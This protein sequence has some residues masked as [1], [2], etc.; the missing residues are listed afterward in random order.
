MAALENWGG[1]VQTL[2]TQPQSI[3]PGN[4]LIGNPAGP[5]MT[6]TGNPATATVWTRQFNGTGGG[7]WTVTVNLNTASATF[8]EA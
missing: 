1:Q 8:V 4:A 2:V 5:P 7:A 6:D 3:L